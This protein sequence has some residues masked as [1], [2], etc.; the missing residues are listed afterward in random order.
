MYTHTYTSNALVFGCRHGRT[1]RHY[2]PPHPSISSAIY[3]ATLVLFIK[4]HT[5]SVRLVGVRV[6]LCNMQTCVRGR[7]RG[8][9]NRNISNE[10]SRGS[11]IVARL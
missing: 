5:P 4:K 8:S 9:L 7:K 1:Y 11:R 2:L 6:Y 10:G 3:N